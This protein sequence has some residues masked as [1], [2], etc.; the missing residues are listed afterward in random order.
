MDEHTKARVIITLACRRTC[1]GCCNN[2]PVFEEHRKIASIDAVAGYAE[3]MLTGGEPMLYPRQTL[4][5]VHHLKAHT[6]ARVY[7]YSALYTRA[8]RITWSE[9]LASL[10]A[11]QFTLHAEAQDGDVAALEQLCTLVAATPHPGRSFRLAI[12]RRL[13]ERYDFSNLDLSGWDV[14]RKMVWIIDAPL[15]AGED[16]FLL[17]ARPDQWVPP[18]AGR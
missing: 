5:L 7:L 13:Y 15:P 12:D 18:E 6:G 4:G 14:V 17:T 10:D 3:I 16:L 11:F 8:D 1:D 9:L 2:M